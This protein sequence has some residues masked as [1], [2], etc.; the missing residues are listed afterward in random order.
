[1]GKYDPLQ[2]YL[3]SQHVTEVELSFS[4]LERIIGGTL[5]KT[6]QHAGFWANETQST[7]GHRRCRS[8]TA[9]G[10]KAS[11]VPGAG[12]VRFL[13][14]GYK[15][16][17]HGEG[18]TFIAKENPSEEERAQA[19]EAWENLI[20]LLART[21]A[22]ASQKLGITFDIE[23]P[24]VAHDVMEATFEGVFGLKTRPEVCA[25]TRRKR[26]RKQARKETG[27]ASD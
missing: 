7:T 27:Q 1:M 14:D 3:K 8:W 23:D 24:Q 25:G 21:A 15:I 12:C 16:V 9:A 19:R 20:K 26:S 13:R 22:K 10:F 5:P 17:S 6:A 4:D 11:F 18:V 2:R